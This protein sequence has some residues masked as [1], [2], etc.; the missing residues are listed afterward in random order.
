MNWPLVGT[1]HRIT[2]WEDGVIFVATLLLFPTALTLYGG[3]AMIFAAKATVDDWA[4]RRADRQRQATLKQE[5]ERITRVLTER[6]IP[7]APEQA[8]VLAG[9]GDNK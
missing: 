1:L 7:L 5:R 8:Q 9:E 6:G 3:F 4:R 2:Q